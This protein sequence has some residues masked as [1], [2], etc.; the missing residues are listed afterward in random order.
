MNFGSILFDLRYPGRNG[1][2]LTEFLR[3]ANRPSVTKFHECFTISSIDLF[4]KK[5]P[6]TVSGM[7]FINQNNV[8]LI[9]KSP[10]ELNLYPWD[11]REVKMY[12]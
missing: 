7:F 10:D 3:S 11:N 8:P 4:V 12:Q 9:K 5:L 6:G 1:F 2:A